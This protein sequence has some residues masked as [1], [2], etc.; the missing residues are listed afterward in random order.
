MKEQLEEIR[1]VAL[2][3]ALETV[4]PYFRDEMTLPCCVYEIVSD[5]IEPTLSDGGRLHRT[6]L[7][8]KIL[9][10]DMAA[11]EDLAVSVAGEFDEFESGD[12]VRSLFRTSIERDYDLPIDGANTPIF[13]V[14]V[15][16]VFWWSE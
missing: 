5:D 16:V 10:D 8:L 6:S 12:Y 13:S 11:V 3:T 7:D 9:D 4:E 15:S 1:G 14:T 2:D